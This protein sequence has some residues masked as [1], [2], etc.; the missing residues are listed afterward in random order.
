MYSWFQDILKINEIKLKTEY[1]IPEKKGKLS[2][3]LKKFT[4]NFD[5]NWFFLFIHLFLI[6]I[7]LKLIVSIQ[8]FILTLL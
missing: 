2:K 5:E 8:L 6:F 4:F 3:H 1:K 7:Y